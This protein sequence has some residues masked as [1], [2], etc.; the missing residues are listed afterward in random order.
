VYR[1]LVNPELP[2]RQLHDQLRISIR[3]SLAAGTGK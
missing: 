3:E 2:M 1:W